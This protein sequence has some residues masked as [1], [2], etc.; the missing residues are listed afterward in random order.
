MRPLSASGRVAVFFDEHKR[1]LRIAFVPSIIVLLFLRAPFSLIH[2]QFWAED[3]VIFF[4]QATRLGIGSLVRPYMGYLHETPRIAA[5]T[6]SFL[7]SVWAPAIYSWTAWL[8]GVGTILLIAGSGVAGRPTLGAIAA[9]AIVFTTNLSQEIFWNLVSAHFVMDAFL[10]MQLV[11][12]PPHTS[13]TAWLRSVFA[14]LAGVTT[15]VS[16]ILLPAILLRL[17]EVRRSKQVW[18]LGMLAVSG[19]VQAWIL[20]ATDC[21]GKAARL[22]GFQTCLEIVGRRIFMEGFVP[23][24]FWPLLNPHPVLIA[25]AGL[26]AL[27]AGV[28][29]ARTQRAACLLLLGACTLILLAAIA[30]MSGSIPRFLDS[31][32]GGYGDRY[33]FPI[34]VSVILILVFVAAAGSRPAR[35]G[36]VILLCAVPLASMPSFSA[37]P[38]PDRQWSRYAPLIDAKQAVD[39]PINPWWIGLYH[40]RPPNN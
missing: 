34:R 26:G 15:P 5:F 29:L 31:G 21:G 13:T 4:D 22:A 10:L 17:L 32:N 2:P 37:P 1:I 19:F 38:Q 33:F 35:I 36:A 6:A 23:A 28:V 30:R 27:A 24:G 18:P 39:V 11:A 8:V 12:D 7:P 16:A 20:L 25:V 40:Y 14:F 3:S 9:L